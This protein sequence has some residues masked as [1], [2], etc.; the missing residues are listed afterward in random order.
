[1]ESAYNPLSLS[2]DPVH[3][4]SERSF[5]STSFS[6]PPLPLPPRVQSLIMPSWIISSLQLLSLE[7]DNFHCTLHVTVKRDFSKLAKIRWWLSVVFQKS[8]PQSLASGFLWVLVCFSDLCPVRSAPHQ[9]LLQVRN[10]DLCPDWVFPW[11]EHPPIYQKVVGSI[12]RHGIHPGCRFHP[13]KGHE[14]EATNLSLFL[15]L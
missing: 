12:P 8:V 6:P 1:M 7:S 11:L 5:K 3:F 9:E 14:W 4:L 13:W 10:T 15:F 2:P